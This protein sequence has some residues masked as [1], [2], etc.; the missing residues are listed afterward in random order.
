MFT[1]S[2]C[3]DPTV[4]LTLLQ[5][6]E[7][8]WGSARTQTW[9]FPAMN[10]LSNVPLSWRVLHHRSGVLDMEM[11]QYHKWAGWT[12]HQR[13]F[14]GNKNKLC[15]L[16]FD[17]WHFFLLL[18][19]LL[20]GTLLS[21]VLGHSDSVSYVGTFGN[22]HKILWRIKGELSESKQESIQS[23]N[24]WVISPWYASH[25]PQRKASFTAVPQWPNRFGQFFAGIFV[26]Q[27]NQLVFHYLSTWFEI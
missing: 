3:E 24:Q 7:I 4:L 6:I 10:S 13:K 12:V 21:V 15:C 18:G 5:L 27:Q 26:P 17:P 20:Q 1:C 2:R 8:G 11:G 16:R 25:I 23:M 22:I 14:G 19:R 9:R